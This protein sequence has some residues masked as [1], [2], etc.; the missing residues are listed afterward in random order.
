MLCYY[1]LGLNFFEQGRKNCE[2]VK[3][4]TFRKEMTFGVKIKTEIRPETSSHLESR[5]LFPK[6]LVVV[7]FFLL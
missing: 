2:T 5:T 4:K 7:V 6:T 3:L 1:F